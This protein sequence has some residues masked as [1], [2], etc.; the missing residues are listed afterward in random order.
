MTFKNTDPGPFYQTPKENDKRR[1]DTVVG[2]KQQKYTKPE[3]VQKLKAKGVRNPK[4]GS[5][6]LQKMCKANNIVTSREVPNIQEGW[7]GKPKGAL[8]V[9]YERGWINPAADPK[10]YTRLLC[11]YYCVCT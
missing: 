1:F 4:G 11:D 3:L 8:Q 2:V 6:K 9:L 5:K 10:E 7:V